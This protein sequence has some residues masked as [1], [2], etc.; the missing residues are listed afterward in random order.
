MKAADA[1]EE[2]TLGVYHTILRITTQP[3]RPGLSPSDKQSEN[4]SESK[5]QNQ[6]ASYSASSQGEGLR[7]RSVTRFYGELLFVILI[8]C[9]FQMLASCHIYVQMYFK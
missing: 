6:R 7:E 3:A 1:Q 8:I 2:P 4:E 9:N 5:P